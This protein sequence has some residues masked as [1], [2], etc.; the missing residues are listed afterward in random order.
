MKLLVDKNSSKPI[1]HYFDKNTKDTI[2]R[3]V[4]FQNSVKG[5]NRALYAQRAKITKTY[6]KHMKAKNWYNFT[7]SAI[8]GNKYFRLL[9]NLK[10][11]LPTI[12][13]NLQF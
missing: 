1:K 8:L 13:L 7:K 12:S 11:L 3:L 5:T 9:N 6:I 2:N 10:Y 4:A